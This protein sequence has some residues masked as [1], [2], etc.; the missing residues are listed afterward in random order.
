MSIVERRKTTR[1]R[2]PNLPIKSFD[3]GTDKVR[4]EAIAYRV[5]G[6]YAISEPGNPSADCP[7]PHSTVT[8]TMDRINAVLRQSICLGI[9]LGNEGTVDTL[10]HGEASAL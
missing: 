2:E 10:E 4:P 1:S 3:D 5:A 8:A 7:G 9:G 6:E